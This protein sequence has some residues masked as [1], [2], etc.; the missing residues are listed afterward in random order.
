[1]KNIL[2]V[3]EPKKKIEVLTNAEVKKLLEEANNIRDKFLIQLLYETG[4]RLGEVLSLRIDDI[5]FDF[6]KG[7]QI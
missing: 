3:K 1:M 2:K 6:R 7:N 5:K 4:L